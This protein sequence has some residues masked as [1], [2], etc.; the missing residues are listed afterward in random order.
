MQQQKNIRFLKV[1]RIEKQL[2]CDF[3]F[4]FPPFFAMYKKRNKFG[5]RWFDIAEE[6]AESVVLCHVLLWMLFSA[7]RDFF[8]LDET[9]YEEKC[10]HN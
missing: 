7:K 2:F 5:G 4:P 9:C 6:E 1:W 10:C 3:G 8:L